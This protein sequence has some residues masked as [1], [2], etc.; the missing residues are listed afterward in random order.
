MGVLNPSIFSK[1]FMT[2][3]RFL[4]FNRVLFKLHFWIGV[5]LVHHNFRGEFSNFNAY[6]CRC[7]HA[8]ERGSGRIYFPDCPYIHWERLCQFKLPRWLSFFR[9]LSVYFEVKDERIGF[10]DRLFGTKLCKHPLRILNSQFTKY[11]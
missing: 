5:F 8:K 11:L 2:W 10:Y 9:L 3:E 4:R 7:K 1:R 6:W